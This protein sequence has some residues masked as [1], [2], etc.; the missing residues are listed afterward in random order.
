MLSVCTPKTPP[1]L[2]GGHSGGRHCRHDTCPHPSLPRDGGR[3]PDF[4]RKCESLIH[5][6]AAILYF[7]APPPSHP[8]IPLDKPGTTLPTLA[9]LGESMFHARPCRTPPIRAKTYRRGLCRLRGAL[10]NWAD[11]PR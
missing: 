7:T 4:P 2:G 3:N 10:S 11:R 1:R 6:E 8:P 9:P 5:H